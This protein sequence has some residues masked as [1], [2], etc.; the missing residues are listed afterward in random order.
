MSATGVLDER[1]ILA[2]LTEAAGRLHGHEDL[3]AAETIST[4]CVVLTRAL[5]PIQ[6]VCEDRAML[7]TGRSRRWLRGR[8]A[9]WME[10]GSARI[11]E[12]AREYRRCALPMRGT[13]RLRIVQ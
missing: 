13:R 5:D 11:H 10:M 12:G 8:H 9:T 4:L 1:Q 2:Q 7:L 6:F 3:Q